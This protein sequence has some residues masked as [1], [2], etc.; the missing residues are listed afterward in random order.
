MSRPKAYHYLMFENSGEEMVVVNPL[1]GWL[2]SVNSTGAR[3]I[4]LCD[5]MHTLDHIIK[6]LVSELDPMGVRSDMEIQIYEFIRDARNKGI[7][8]FRLV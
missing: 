2:C 5:G 3:I 6:I 1:L 8:L 4:E 7:I